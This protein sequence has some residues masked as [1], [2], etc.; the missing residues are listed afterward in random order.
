[1]TLGDNLKEL[2]EQR[3]VNVSTLS[4]KC[5]VPATTIRSW[6]KKGKA[7]PNDASQIKRIATFM[8]VSVER[9]IFGEDPGENPKDTQDPMKKLINEIEQKILSWRI[10]VTIKKIPDRDVD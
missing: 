2:L 1:M 5:N 3:R 9:L 7:L 10:E 8:G 4:K 6:L